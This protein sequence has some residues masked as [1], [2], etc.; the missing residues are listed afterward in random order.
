MAFTKADKQ[1]LKENFS[2]KD[3]LVAMEKRQ[4]AKYSTKDDVRN[5]QSAF[6][7]ALGGLQDYIDEKFKESYRLLPTKEEFF[8]RMDK[9]SREYEKIDQAETLHNG[10][11]SD[12]TDTLENHD[13]RIKAL[14]RRKISTPAPLIPTAA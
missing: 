8:A 5:L 13:E 14:E 1:F 9:L 11:L 3:D 7:V 6:K 12:H 4:D 2:T 10:R